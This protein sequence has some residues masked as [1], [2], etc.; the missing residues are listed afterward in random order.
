MGLCEIGEIGLVGIDQSSKETGCSSVRIKV[1]NDF[2]RPH[3]VV[4]SQAQRLVGA[5]VGAYCSSD[6]RPTQEE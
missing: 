5:M 4:P 3:Y 1:T 2:S 6:L